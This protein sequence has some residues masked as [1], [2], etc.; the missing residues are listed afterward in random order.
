VVTAAQEGW[1]AALGVI[2]A[3]FF[4]TAGV[5]AYRALRSPYQRR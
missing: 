1:L 3:L 5:Y 4:I 2:P